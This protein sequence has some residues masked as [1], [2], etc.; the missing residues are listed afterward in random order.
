MKTY[1]VYMILFDG[2]ETRIKIVTTTKTRKQAKLNAIN[3]MYN[4]YGLKPK[5]NYKITKTIQMKT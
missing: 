5:Q 2:T 4:K 3:K 1:N